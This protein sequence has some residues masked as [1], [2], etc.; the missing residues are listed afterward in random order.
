MSALKSIVLQNFRGFSEHKIEFGP[1]T[2]LIG[3]NN[4]GKTT[5][6]EALRILSVCQTR[7]PTA[8]FE[9]VP[10]WLDGHCSGAG[11]FRL[12]RNNRL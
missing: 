1:E 4:A 12:S 9:P 10:E 7:I 11:F 3:K 8:L 5:V 2:I 6:I